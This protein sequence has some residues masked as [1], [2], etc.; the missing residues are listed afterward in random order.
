MVGEQHQAAAQNV[1][2]GL[3]E[4]PAGGELPVN[5][6]GRGPGLGDAA[7]KRVQNPPAGADHARAGQVERRQIHVGECR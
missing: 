2:A 5:R 7:G 3:V 4:L 6:P 1:G